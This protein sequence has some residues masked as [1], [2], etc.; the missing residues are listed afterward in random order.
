MKEIYTKKVKRD[1]TGIVLAHIIKDNLRH[2]HQS[3]LG[4]P[5]E[6][7]KHK[8]K[9]AHKWADKMIKLLEKYEIQ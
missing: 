5:F 7:D 6:T 9:R 3:F 2:A 1:D 8:L 4:Y